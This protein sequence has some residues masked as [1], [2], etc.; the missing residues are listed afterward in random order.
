MPNPP[1]DDQPDIVLAVLAS[2]ARKIAQAALEQQGSSSSQMYYGGEV[3]HPNLQ[4]ATVGTP[5]HERWS[6]AHQKAVLAGH[7]PLIPQD[8]HQIEK[9]QANVQQAMDLLVPTE[10]IDQTQPDAI[11]AT[12]ANMR[13]DCTTPEAIQSFLQTKVTCFQDALQLPLKSRG[14]WFE[15][16]S[17]RLGSFIWVFAWKGFGV[18]VC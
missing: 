18:V 4:E 7:G 10:I 6:E 14:T 12:V 16:N 17:Q 8:S 3:P 9:L 1:A 13:L 5:T 2:R 11:T 15:R